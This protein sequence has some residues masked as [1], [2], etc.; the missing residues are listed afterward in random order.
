MY[1]RDSRREPEAFL[2]SRINST[3]VVP[4]SVRRER[5]G[6]GHVILN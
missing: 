3:H 2:A 5:V 4:K 1:K 6:S